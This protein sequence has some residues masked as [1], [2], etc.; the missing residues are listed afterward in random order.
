M[1]LQATCTN[2]VFDLQFYL[3]NPGDISRVRS[4][5]SRLPSGSWSLGCLV[6]PMTSSEAT[7]D[8]WRCLKKII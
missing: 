5:F 4:P 6:E 8:I 3:P 2:R 1:N 7:R